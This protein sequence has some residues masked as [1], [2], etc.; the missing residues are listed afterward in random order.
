[1]NIELA[2]VKLEEREV[3]ANLLEK[4]NYEFSQYNLC[5][6]NG[7]GL[8]GYKWLDCYWIEDDRWAFFIKV[9]GN[10]AGFAMV[11]DIPEAPDRPMDYS[12]AELFV[13]YKYR[14][15]GAGTLAA[16][17]V[18]SMFK[19]HWQLKRHPRNI[20]SVR[21]WDKAV[22][23]FTGGEYELVR[24]YPGTEYEDGTPGDVFFF[25]SK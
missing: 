9:D 1:M 5:D 20:G 3:P 12:L 19:G 6:V 21:F 4:Y 18:F 2:P 15:L 25:E 24:A 10:L 11:N 8:Y 23:E 13:M 14:R 22:A 17:S 16:K 7:L